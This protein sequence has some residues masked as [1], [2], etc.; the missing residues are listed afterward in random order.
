MTQFVPKQ[1]DDNGNVT[2]INPLKEMVRLTLGI[3]AIIIALLIIFHITF[4]FIVRH[5]SVETENRL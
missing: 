5:I 3:T 4:D 1:F 2:P